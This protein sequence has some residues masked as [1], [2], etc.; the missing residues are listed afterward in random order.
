MH[1]YE[2]QVFVST[3]RAR[4]TKANVYACIPIATPWQTT[5]ITLC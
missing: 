2:Q 1:V 5:P 4:L 3:Y